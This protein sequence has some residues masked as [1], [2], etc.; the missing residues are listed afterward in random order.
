VTAASIIDRRT[1]STG[2]MYLFG[3]HASG[4]LVVFIG[5]IAAAYAV[6]GSPG[7]PLAFLLVT[8]VLGLL[9][10][11]YAAMSRRVPH[12]APYYATIARG[13][14]GPPGWRLGWSR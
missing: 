7:L 1:M 4:P 12:G 14:G 3:V 9:A 5:A 8:V 2:R 10:E 13:L 6:S 11:G